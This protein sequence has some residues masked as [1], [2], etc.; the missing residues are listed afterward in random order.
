MFVDGVL[1]LKFLYIFLLQIIF[2]P[3]LTQFIPMVEGWWWAT[4]VTIGGGDSSC[5]GRGGCDGK[6]A[7]FDIFYRVMLQLQHLVYNRL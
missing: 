1:I 4:K 5:D 3:Y 2:V 7:N 6:Y